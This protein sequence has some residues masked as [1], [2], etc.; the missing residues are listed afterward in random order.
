MGKCNIS[1]YIPIQEREREKREESGG[2]PQKLDTLH[3]FFSTLDDLESRAFQRSF[4]ACTEGTS[5]A[6][7]IYRKKQSV[8]ES[9]ESDGA[10]CG[11]E[12]EEA[13]RTR[14]RR[15]TS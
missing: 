3:L 7:E 6:K 14:F 1:L 2:D 9:K 5:W 11:R 4:E 13:R 12:P 15:R 8:R 10:T